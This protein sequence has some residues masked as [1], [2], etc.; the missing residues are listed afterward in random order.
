MGNRIG[1]FGLVGIVLA[2]VAIIRVASVEAQASESLTLLKYAFIP[3]LCFALIGCESLYLGGISKFSV[4]NIVSFVSAI[5]VSSVA[6]VF[7]RWAPENSLSQVKVSFAKAVM[8]FSAIMFLYVVV[9]YVFSKRR[10]RE[11][12]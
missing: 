8:F 1:V 11:I 2:A 5:L 3:V 9:N 7:F 6:L 4:R 12:A 10:P